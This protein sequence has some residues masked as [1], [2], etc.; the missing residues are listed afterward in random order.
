MKS[1]HMRAERR[2]QE[3]GLTGSQTLTLARDYEEQQREA[4]EDL[5]GSLTEFIAAP[6]TAE[7]LEF[8]EQRLRAKLK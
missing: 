8:T 5:V 7:Q 1:A 3:W 4:I 2:R 6:L